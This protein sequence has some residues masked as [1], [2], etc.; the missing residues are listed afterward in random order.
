MKIFVLLAITIMY[1]F[2]YMAMD[3]ADPTAFGF[4]NFID[5]FYFAF[6][7][8]STVGYGDLLPQNT[9]A[10]SVVMTQQFILLAEILDLVQFAKKIP[11]PKVP[12]TKMM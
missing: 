9:F 4:E 3:K 2:I 7:T 8:M 10:K 5:P 12:I 6:T 1:G 11:V